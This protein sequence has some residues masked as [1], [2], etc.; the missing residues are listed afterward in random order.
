M[1][2]KYNWSEL[3]MTMYD[4]LNTIVKTLAFEGKAKGI[5]GNVEGRDPKEDRF[6]GYS[7]LN[8]VNISSNFSASQM[9]SRI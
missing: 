4:E 1:S 2:E 5:I 3:F 6:L 7:G 9:F 8:S